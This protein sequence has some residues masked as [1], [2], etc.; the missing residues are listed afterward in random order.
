MKEERKARMWHP[1]EG[2]VHTWIDGAATE[3]ETRRIEAHLEECGSCRTLVAE[4]R[5]L[6]AGA[7][8]IIGALDRVPA[9]VIPKSSHAAAA[10]APSGARRA[11][12]MSPAFRIAASLVFVAGVSSIV[13]RQK[14][15]APAKGSIPQQ[16]A[17]SEGDFS[18]AAGGDSIP[19]IK[20]ATDIPIPP[21]VLLGEERRPAGSIASARSRAAASDV[22]AEAGQ[23]VAALARTDSSSVAK[24]AVVDRTATF[25]MQVQSQ[26][27]SPILS[28]EQLAQVQRVLT[29]VPGSATRLDRLPPVLGDLA[30]ADS[31][32]VVAERESAGCYVLTALSVDNDA[33]RVDIAN[34]LVGMVAL[35]S[36]PN[37]N[38]FSDSLLLQQTRQSQT[39]AVAGGARGGGRGGGGGGRGGRAAGG[40]AP[41]T[42][43]PAAAA[44]PLM[45]RALGWRVISRDSIELRVAI[46]TSLIAMRLSRSSDSSWTGIA[47]V[48]S[49]T[50]LG[51][52]ANVTALKAQCE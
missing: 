19:A 51:A 16:V 34:S 52:V 47:H 18:R 27:V 3:D 23:K 36:G 7:S 15:P 10:G 13:V 20:A 6:V 22:V 48:A 45:S 11:F 50:S 49:D 42:T 21:V 37:A 24:A 2:L 12:W 1:E 5:G 44:P 41:P 40:A 14:F 46:D 4:E 33:R 38:V 32:I 29:D 9:D 26:S 39:G 43:P 30:R 25:Q 31:A 28:K 17:R 35:E 8:R